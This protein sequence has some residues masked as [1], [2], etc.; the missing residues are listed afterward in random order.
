MKISTMVIVF[1]LS[2]LIGC[3]FKSSNP[4]VKI[5]EINNGVFVKYAYLNDSILLSEQQFLKGLDGNYIAN[6]YSKFYY[7]NGILADSVYY[8]DDKK[9]GVQWSFY[10]NGNIKKASYFENGTPDSGSVSYYPNGT[11]SDWIFRKEHQLCGLQYKYDTLGNQILISFYV[12]NS[13]KIFEVKFGSRGKIEQM[14]GMP[15]YLVAKSNSRHSRIGEVYTIA[16]LVFKTRLIKP[17]LDIKLMHIN[18]SSIVEHKT[19]TTFQQMHNNSIYYSDFNFSKAGNYLYKAEIKLYD[20]SESLL[21]SYVL[22][23]TIFVG[24]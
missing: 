9:Q 4:K 7:E 22:E 3:N 23:D 24:R 13:E 2:C 5:I 17:V 14:E 20:T 19:I 11:M 1:L 21:N 12:K 16:N 8:I 18:S 15:L 10:A 6:G